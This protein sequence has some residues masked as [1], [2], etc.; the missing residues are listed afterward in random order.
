MPKIT[1]IGIGTETGKMILDDYKNWKTTGFKPWGKGVGSTSHYYSRK[2]YQV[3]TS[4]AFCLQA[5]KI[6]K[7]ALEQMPACKLDVEGVEEKKTGQKDDDDESFPIDSE[8]KNG[9]KRDLFSIEDENEDKDDEE[10]D[11]DDEEDTDFEANNDDDDDTNSKDSLEDFDDVE[12]G[13]LGNSRTSFLSQYPSGDKLLAVFPLDGDVHDIDSNVFEFI[14]NNTAIRRLGR[15]P[16]ERENCVALI[17][18]G[19]EKRTGFGF[20]DVDLMVI[21]AEIQKRLKVNQYDRDE[22]GAIWEIRDTLRLPFRCVPQLYNKKGKP[23]DKFRMRS[24]DLGFSW[25]YF[26]LLAWKPQVKK[27]AQ[28]IGGKLVTV[29]SKEDSSVYTEKTVQSNRSGRPISE[30][31]FKTAI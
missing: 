22:K 19:T 12:L 8:K 5:K 2:S 13:E 28:R 7:Y 20:S 30:I 15:V 23:L 25:G 11:D 27:P 31:K 9:W 17:G 29:M 14:D 18:L 10:D 6:E 21:D 16:K 4:S 3:V 24:N 26:W 1:A